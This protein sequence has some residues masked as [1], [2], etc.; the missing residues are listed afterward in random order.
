MSQDAVGLFDLLETLLALGDVLRRN[1]AFRKIDISYITALPLA[2]RCQEQQQEE[3]EHT[4]LFINTN[5]HNNLII[6]NTDQL[7]HAPDPPP[8]QLTEQNHAIDIVILK[9]LHIDAHLSV[10]GGAV[11]LS[12]SVCP[13]RSG[14]FWTHLLDVHHHYL[15]QLW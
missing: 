11:S 15:V 3:E 1:P 8:R 10:L 9:Q 14:W 6:S 5:D 12:S 7:L 13:V 4:F 2:R